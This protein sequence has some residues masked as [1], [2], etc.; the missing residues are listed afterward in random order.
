MALDATSL[1]RLLSG[2]DE[3]V[4]GVLKRFNEQSA[5]MKSFAH[6]DYFT[7]KV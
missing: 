4:V 5:D 7:R 2:P 3:D 1:K 6:V